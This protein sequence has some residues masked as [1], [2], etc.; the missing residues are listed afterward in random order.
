[1]RCRMSLIVNIK[2]VTIDCDSKVAVLLEF[3]ATNTESKAELLNL[4]KLQGD[5]VLASF[6]E[7]QPSI[8]L[9]STNHNE[10]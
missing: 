3:L 4:I 2:K 1:M 8:K 10:L 6:K 9:D 5:A 7:A